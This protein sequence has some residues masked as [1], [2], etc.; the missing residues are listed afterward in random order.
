MRIVIAEDVVLFRDGLERIMTAAGFSVVGT[1]GSADDVVR[2]VADVAPDV[3]LIDVRMPPTHTD[4]GLRAALAVRAQHPAVGVLMLSQYADSDLALTLLADGRGGVGY[5]LKDSVMNVA[6]LTDAVWRVSKGGSVVDATLITRLLGRR[7]VRSPLDE[8]TEREHSV[9]ALMAE[10][11]SNAAIAG[12]L[13]LSE[14]TVE[15]HVSSIF[16]KLSLED[17]ADDHRRVLAVIAYLQH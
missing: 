15:S 5:L 8:L 9:L 11:R 6:E 3:A 16:S 14:R 1:V 10:G 17:A 12:R 4:D 7:R 13:F 2:L